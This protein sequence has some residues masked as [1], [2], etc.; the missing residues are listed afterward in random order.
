MTESTQVVNNNNIA[1]DRDASIYL[2]KGTVLRNRYQI[3]DKLAQGGFGITY[4]A[5]D[6]YFEKVVVIK[7]FYMKNL[8]IRSGHNSDVIVTGNSESSN[9]FSVFKNKFLK[10]ART[11]AKFKECESIVNVLDIFE[12]NGT[13]YYVMDFIP[14]ESLEE[15]VKKKGFLSIE[16]SHALIVDV[17]KTLE[18]IHQ[19]NYLHLDITPRNIMRND[20]GKIIL[21]DFGVSK[22]YEES[23]GIQTTTTSVAHSPGYAPLEQYRSEV[24]TFYPATDIYSLG[25]VYYFLLTGKRPPEA[26]VDLELDFPNRVPTEVQTIITHM[27]QPA[28]KQ[29]PQNIKELM[30]ILVLPSNTPTIEPINEN[31]TFNFT[32]TIDTNKTHEL[33]PFKWIIIAIVVF[34]AIAYI[35]Q[36]F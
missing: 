9:Q 34:F 12:S 6:N 32:G 33:I 30:Q 36:Y 26:D 15:Y 13:A 35:S 24:S 29:R 2:P 20:Q 11:I 4:K 3:T 27:M 16:E 7:E 8:S 23:A 25:A 28:P 18:F 21:I 10:E 22:H 5:I 1:K 17:A 19:N 14:G 31:G